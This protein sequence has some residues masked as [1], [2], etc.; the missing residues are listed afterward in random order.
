MTQSYEFE[1]AVARMR[2]QQRAAEQREARYHEAR[3][4]MLISHFTTTKKGL[5][6][7]PNSISCCAIPQCW[8]VSFPPAWRLGRK[9]PPRRHRNA[10][11]SRAG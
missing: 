2:T 7:L 6:S 4:L 11:P 10:W 8:N 9:E 1:T 3:V 5:A